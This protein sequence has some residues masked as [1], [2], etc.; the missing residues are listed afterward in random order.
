MGKDYIREGKCPICGKNFVI[1]PNTVYRIKI[2]NSIKTYCSYTCFRV[3][4]KRQESKRQKRKGDR[5]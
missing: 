1:P 4:Q 5:K 3:E 2:G